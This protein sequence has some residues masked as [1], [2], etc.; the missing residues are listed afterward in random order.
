MGKKC[1]SDS[2]LEVLKNGRLTGNH[3]HFIVTRSPFMVTNIVILLTWRIY[4]RLYCCN[5]FDYK[6]SSLC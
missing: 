3:E 5:A 4:E 2:L 1:H 6:P